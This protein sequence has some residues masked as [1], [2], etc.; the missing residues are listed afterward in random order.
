MCVLLLS[1]PAVMMEREA[2][3]MPILVELERE[4]EQRLRDLAEREKRPAEDLCR[5]L[6]RAYLESRA[7]APTNASR[8]P[9]TSLRAMIGLAGGG[10]TDSSVCHDIRPGED[11]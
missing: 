4:E 7:P 10:P 5:D 11:V 1:G 9:Y 2:G 8:D 6:V 3:L